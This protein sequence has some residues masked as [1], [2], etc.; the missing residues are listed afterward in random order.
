MGSASQ[1]FSHVP[2]TWVAYYTRTECAI[3]SIKLWD[4]GRITST[5]VRD[6]DCFL[7]TAAESLGSFQRDGTPVEHARKVAD[8]QPGAL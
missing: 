5:A 7:D 3:P 2:K 1:K 4:G 6:S 8:T